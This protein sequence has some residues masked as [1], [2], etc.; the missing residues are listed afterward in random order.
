M[1]GYPIKIIN[2][3]IW[4]EKYSGNPEW[5]VQK[6]VYF[7]SNPWF[8]LYLE[9]KNNYRIGYISAFLFQLRQTLVE[10]AI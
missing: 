7:K 6:S 2:G 1:F 3:Q 9:F 5:I 8:Q 10:L 4:N